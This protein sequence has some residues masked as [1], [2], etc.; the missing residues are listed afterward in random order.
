TPMSS[1]IPGYEYDIFISYRQKDN[2]HDGWVTEFV[3]N[4]KG[5]LE[6]T[7]KEE[8][9]VYFDI[10]PHDGL[11]ETHDVDASLK[12][13][14]KCLVFI[15]I[16]SRTYCDPKSFAW[17]YEFKSFIEQA[18]KDQYGLKVKLPGGNVANRIL[19]VQI[20]D[21]ENDDRKLVENELG[22]YIRGIEFI[23]KEPGVNKPL[24]K[25]DDEKKNLNNTKYKI[26]INK[27]ANAIKEVITAIQQHTPEQEE[28]AK[29]VFK[30]E[31]VPRKNHKTIIIVALLI[32]LTS[33]ILGFI[34]VPKLFKPSGQLEKSIAVLPFALLSDEPDKQYL[35][36]GMMDAITLHLSKIKDL[37]VMSRTSV[38][39]YR[40]P[41][42]T[43]TAI[44]RELDVEYLLEGSFQKF[45]DSVRLIVQL[46]KTGKEGHVW[47][48]NYDRSWKSVFSV[49]SEVAQ[50]IARELQAVI[51]PEEKELIEKAPTTNLTAYEIYIK[52][53]EY[54]K[55]YEK[56]R[57]LDTYQNTISL[58]RTSITID[59]SFAKAYTGLAKAY[60]SRYYWESYFQENFMD[61]CFALAEIAL[62][63]DN[64]L[65]EAYYLKGE[66]YYNNGKIEEALDNLDEALKIN[67]NYYS[68]YY[69]KG[70]ILTRVRND[71]VKG[72]ENFHKALNIIQGSERSSLLR[73]LGYTYIYAGFY[74]K[75]KY[76]F[77]GALS[78]NGDSANYF[79]NLVFVESSFENF[80]NVQLLN[81]KISEIDSTYLPATE[82]FSFRGQHQEAYTVAKKRVERYRKSGELLLINSHRIGY[83][84]WKVGKYKEARDYFNQQIK[85]GTESIRLSRDIAS[86]KNAQYNLA[87]TYAFLG[88]KT[89]AYKYLDE[90]NTMN[91]YPKWWIVYLKYD[92]LFDSIR[93]EERFQKIL[94][95]VE[96]KYQAEHERVRKWLEEQ[97]EL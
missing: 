75:A 88:D 79:N 2:K 24:T 67:P 31:F 56:T 55:E 37:R 74:D 84:Y 12:N 23:Y 39:Q 53:N 28:V 44:G 61:S 92:V 50:A 86:T 54:L 1:L 41:T 91:F 3:N 77:Q 97:G 80:E 27:V 17:E 29:E 48:N 4:L 70:Y 6:S 57:N 19:P 34:F 85:Y 72:L 5:E 66:Y 30:P 94:Q 32:V 36:D 10:N 11:L 42:K 18:S 20:H 89:M 9:S 93:N 58:Y 38:E 60:W 40:H 87:A 33:I 96:A 35:A 68:A 22:G 15:P 14:L 64:Q 26:Q 49:Q 65:D 63:F 78:M 8:I 46:I 52:A 43:T 83:A 69:T 76:Y 95:N 13:K 45:G 59:S 25:D 7:F 62:R 81:E 71:Y 82:W 21:L 90:F 51:T 16:I 73:A 47:A